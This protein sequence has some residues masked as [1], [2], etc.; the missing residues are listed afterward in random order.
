MCD[1]G[2]VRDELTSEQEEVERAIAELRLE[3]TLRAVSAAEAL[4]LYGALE[5][6]FA[7]RR[8]ACW[9]W[10]HLRA[11]PGSR[12]FTDEKPFTRLPVS[13]PIASE[14]LLFFPGS[15][16]HPP[17]AFRGTI[18]VITRVLGNCFAFEYCVAPPAMDW[19]VCENHHD[20]LFAVGEVVEARL[21]ALPDAENGA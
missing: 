15:D 6:R 19:L 20:V 8:G 5:G 7:D 12:C 21:A 13:V 4:E 3:G 14:E 2:T 11:R 1:E 9:I 10:E 17:C 18:D 16:E